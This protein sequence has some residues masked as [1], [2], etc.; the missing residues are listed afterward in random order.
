MNHTGWPA[1]AS[2]VVVPLAKSST[3]TR[4][5]MSITPP[6]MMVAPASTR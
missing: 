2:R 3:S 6:V 5:A 1:N 4:F